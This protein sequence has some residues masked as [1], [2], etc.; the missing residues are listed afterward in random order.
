MQRPNWQALG[1]LHAEHCA[2]FE[3]HANVLEPG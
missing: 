3:P 2:P 1:P